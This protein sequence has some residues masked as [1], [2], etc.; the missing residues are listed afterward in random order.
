[1]STLTRPRPTRPSATRFRPGPTGRAVRVAVPVP[2]ERR[3][4]PPIESDQR[5]AQR[6]LVSTTFTPPPSFSHSRRRLPVS[7]HLTAS[8]RPFSPPLRCLPLPVS[9]FHCPS[10][11]L[12]HWLFTAFPWHFGRDRDECRWNTLEQHQ[13]PLGRDA[14]PVT[15]HAPS[16]AGSATKE[17]TCR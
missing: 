12:F 16:P 17:T 5:S 15:A 14:R 8:P 10:T 7:V 11:T 1:M 3:T 4:V 2:I 9:A 13:G 6:Q